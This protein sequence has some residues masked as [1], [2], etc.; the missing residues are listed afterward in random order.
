MPLDKGKKKFIEAIV[1]RLTRDKNVQ[2]IFG[3]CAIIS[4]EGK[5]LSKAEVKAARQGKR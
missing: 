2:V 3:T 1:L 4:T 5:P